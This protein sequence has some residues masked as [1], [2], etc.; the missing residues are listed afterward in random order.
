MSSL[1]QHSWFPKRTGN[2]SLSIKCVNPE[3]PYYLHNLKK[4]WTRQISQRIAVKIN[5]SSITSTVSSR[6][7]FFSMGLNTL[8]KMPLFLKFNKHN[9]HVM[10]FMPDT[11]RQSGPSSRKTSQALKDLYNISISHQ[12]TVNYCK[13]LPFVSSPL[14]TSILLRERGCLH[15]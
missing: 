3:C 4:S 15:C 6:W 12:Q 1:R 9:A 14:S 10:S 8:P 5:I 11:A 7:I 2:T 13:P